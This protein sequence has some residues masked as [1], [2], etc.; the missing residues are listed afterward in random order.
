MKKKIIVIGEDNEN[1]KKL[2][3][4][5]DIEFVE[6]PYKET[7]ENMPLEEIKILKNGYDYLYPPLPKKLK[8]VE[9]KS[10]RNSKTN[11]KYNRNQ[12]CPCGSGKKYKNCCLTL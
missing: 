4:N 9:V 12:L 6:N 8:N 10:I 5:F 2:K 7:F 1:F 3:D 11:P